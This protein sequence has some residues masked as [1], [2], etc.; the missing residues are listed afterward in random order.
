MKKI[1]Q[2]HLHCFLFETASILLAWWLIW[3]E[4]VCYSSTST[5]LT[6]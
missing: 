2:A 1:S 4:K 5:H 3:E 6:L